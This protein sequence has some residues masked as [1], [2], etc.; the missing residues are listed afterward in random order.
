MKAQ[1]SS[2]AATPLQSISSVY[3]K[4]V[5]ICNGSLYVWVGVR[6]EQKI[7]FLQRNFYMAVTYARVIIL[8]I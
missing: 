5:G 1:P 2:Y 7:I 3:D 4:L 6:N 8:N